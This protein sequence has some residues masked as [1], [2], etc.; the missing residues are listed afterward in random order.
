MSHLAA[1]LIV[2]GV[3]EEE[4]PAVCLGV[5]L[6]LKAREKK[7][8][9]SEFIR[10]KIIQGAETVLPGGLTAFCGGI[11]HSL[12]LRLNHVRVLKSPWPARK[13]ACPRYS[14]M[15]FFKIKNYA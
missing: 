5:G 1:D 15:S 12:G 2:L 13:T 3:D 10:W 8:H 4:Q 7:G 6:Q 14:I 9:I 11:H